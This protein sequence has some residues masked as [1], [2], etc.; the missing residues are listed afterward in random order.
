V[1]ARTAL[2]AALSLATAAA[3]ADEP[4]ARGSGH[5][6]S[7]GAGHG[8]R[9]GL[10]ASAAID[11]RG[12]L[13]AVRRE[14]ERLVLQRSTD[15]G[16]T[17]DAPRFVTAAPE[18]AEADSDSRPKVALGRGGEVYVTWTRP[19]SRPFTGEIR[20]ARSL[21]GGETFSAA[22]TVHAEDPEV[23]RRFDA[24]AVD[25]AGRVVVA[26]LDKRDREAARARGEPY[27]GAALYVVR[28]EDRGATFGPERKLADHACECCRIAVRPLGDGTVALLW[29]HVFEPGIRD[30]ALAVLGADGVPGPVRRATVDDWAIDACPHQ[31]PSLA[32]VEGGLQ[33]VW[34]TRGPVREGVY[35]GRLGP[36]G[37]TRIRRVGGPAAAHGDLASDGRRLA[38][39]WKEFDGERTRLR[40]LVS[41]DAGETWTERELASTGGPSGQPQVLV[42]GGRFLAFWHTR[43]ER[44]LVEAIP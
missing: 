42:Q 23:G 12:R 43:E 24:L 19:L 39:A 21:D 32:A 1:R 20:F 41:G 9:E 35:T 26:W 18:P 5:A 2:L 15:A 13:F 8:P 44:L 11:A 30:H 10:G 25:A 28:S 22:R 36:E 17:W 31:G 27:A 29:R 3:R 37:P 33:A 34:F 38:V 16:R 7:A 40:A 4:R 14:G 6:S